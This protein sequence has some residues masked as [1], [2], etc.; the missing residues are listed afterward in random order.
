MFEHLD[1]PQ[2][3]VVRPD[4]RVPI[5]RL[6]LLCVALSKAAH[7][8][9]HGHGDP[10]G[11]AERWIIFTT[12]EV[13]AMDDATSWYQAQGEPPARAELL[14]RRVRETMAASR[15]PVRAEDAGR[16]LVLVSVQGVPGAQAPALTAL[17]TLALEVADRLGGEVLADS[18]PLPVVV[19]E[20]DGGG[21][22]MGVL[23]A[24]LDR[25]DLLEIEI[26]HIL[27]TTL[28]ALVEQDPDLGAWIPLDRDPTIRLREPSGYSGL[29]LVLCAFTVASVS[30]CKQV[31]D[32]TV[33]DQAFARAAVVVEQIQADQAAAR[34]G[35]PGSLRA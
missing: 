13:A 27:C 35:Q 3:L 24:R 23:A 10:A 14:A 30:A 1:A 29:P 12:G 8:H 32:G 9:A 15:H 6:Q 18:F 4:P 17:A 22:W 31:R 16:G 21:A 2:V 26:R 5:D 11:G 28:Q 19:R 34:C 7:A 25:P 20:V 33:V